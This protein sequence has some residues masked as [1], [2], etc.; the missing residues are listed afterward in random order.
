MIAVR[1]YPC[2]LCGSWTGVD[3][4]CEGCRAFICLNCEVWRPFGAPHSPMSHVAKLAEALP[5][6][7]YANPTG[8]KL[9]AKETYESITIKELQNAVDLINKLSPLYF[10]PAMKKDFEMVKGQLLYE[11]TVKEGTS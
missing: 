3:R 10:S 8:Q 11:I 5:S 2:F 1:T 7:E 9:T 6:L 4:F